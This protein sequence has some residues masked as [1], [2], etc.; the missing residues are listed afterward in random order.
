M[1]EE[2]DTLNENNNNNQDQKKHLQEEGSE[3]PTEMNRLT[4]SYSEV[5]DENN[6]KKQTYNFKIIVVGDIAVGKTSVI[7][8]YIMNSFTEN[9]K[10]ALGCEYKNKKIDI[11]AETD[12][13]LQIWDTA[14]EER[15]MSVT[16]QYYNDSH[17]AIVLFDLTKK[18]SFEKV[19]KWIKELKDNAPKNIVI[20]VVGN[21]SDLINE[22]VDLGNE[23][24]KY[25]NNYL[26]SEVS[27]K[28]GTNV[29]LAF[30]NLTFK[31][32]EEEQ[33]KKL[34]GE[35]VPRVTIALKKDS[36]G[37]KKKKCTCPI[38]IPWKLKK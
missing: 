6:N 28:S 37:K 18:E 35:D 3:R 27:A 12:A 30:E 24:N 38:P 17:G 31:I 11:D 34:K 15:F 19:D 2:E 10:S 5:D 4:D 13:N 9:Y 25:K 14:G 33:E 8:R 1:K 20:M 26:Y 7:N 21:K 32:I 29:S 16:K 23:L 36:Q 22:K